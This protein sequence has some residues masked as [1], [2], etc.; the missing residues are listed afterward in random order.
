MTFQAYASGPRSIDT[1]S[2]TAPVHT[3]SP[4]TTP[5]SITLGEKGKEIDMNSLTIT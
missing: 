1:R 4:Q 5:P 2:H 3:T